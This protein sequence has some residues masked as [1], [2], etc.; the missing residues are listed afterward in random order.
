M[1]RFIVCAV[2]A[3]AFATT[4]CERRT[5]TGFTRTSAGTATAA[6]NSTS[7]TSTADVPGVLAA[8]DVVP[9]VSIYELPAGFIDQDGAP[10]KLDAYRGHPTLVAMFYASCPLACP[11]LIAN[12]KNLE[13]S[14]S[15]VERADL[16]VLLVTIDPE[17]DTPEALRGVIARHKLDAARW[18][19]FTGKEDDIRDAAAVLGIKYRESDGTINHSSV[20]TLVDRE[21]R[22]QGR[23]DGLGDARPAAGPKL[24]ELLAKKN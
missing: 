20:I 10:G 21:G 23:Y 2:A 24:R 18:K 4:S 15:A 11:R 16:R 1:N 7:P 6:P 17:N 14:L 8:G 19:L 3:L 12:V 22:I 13:A 9:G 5:P